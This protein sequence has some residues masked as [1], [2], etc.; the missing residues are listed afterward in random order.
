MAVGGHAR[1][2]EGMCLARG[3]ELPMQTPPPSTQ[4]VSRRMG[5][6]MSTGMVCKSSIERESNLQPPVPPACIQPL[7]HIPLVELRG[8]SSSAASTTLQRTHNLASV[9]EHSHVRRQAVGLHDEIG[10]GTPPLE[11]PVQLLVAAG[12]HRSNQRYWKTSAPSHDHG[13]PNHGHPVAR[14]FR[15]TT[16]FVVQEPQHQR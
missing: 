11:G 16:V 5:A 1:G 10:G 9:S 13:L 3:R 7:N 4:T 6:M 8:R 14:R 12:A 2:P 15:R